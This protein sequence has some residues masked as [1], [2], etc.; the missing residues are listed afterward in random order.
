MRREIEMGRTVKMGRDSD[1]EGDGEGDG[2][3][4]K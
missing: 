4:H 2:K 1:K 3:L